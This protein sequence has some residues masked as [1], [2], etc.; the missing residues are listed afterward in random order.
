MPTR[1]VGCLTEDGVEEEDGVEDLPEEEGV[2]AG[3]PEEPEEV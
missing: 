3:E 2:V 1:C